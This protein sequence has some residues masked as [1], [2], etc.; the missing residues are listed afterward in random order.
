MDFFIAN[1]V[2]PLK[3]QIVQ[4]S[5]VLMI[6]QEV[7]VHTAHC[8]LIKIV[9]GRNRHL[10]RKILNNLKGFENISFL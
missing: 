10:N 1:R 6:F 5:I 7:L 9:W 3:P 4:G 8:S 2:S